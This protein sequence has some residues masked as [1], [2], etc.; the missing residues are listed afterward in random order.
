M[1]DPQPPNPIF[2][3]GSCVKVRRLQG[4]YRVLSS[5]LIGGKIRRYRLDAIPGT[6][7]LLPGTEAFGE[8]MQRVPDP[9]AGPELS[10]APDPPAANSAPQEHSDASPDP[11]APAGERSASAAVCSPGPGITL[12]RDPDEPR[13]PREWTMPAGETN[14]SLPAGDEEV[15][16][17]HDPELVEFREV[18]GQPKSPPVPS[19]VKELRYYPATAMSYR[20]LKNII[21]SSHIRGMEKGPYEELDNDTPVGVA[22]TRETNG[23]AVWVITVRD[24]GEVREAQ[25][26][27]FYPSDRIQDHVMKASCETM[28]IEYGVLLALRKIPIRRNDLEILLL[29]L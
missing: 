5:R 15:D 3:D 12:N 8:D 28:A 27:I 20:D 6:G 25:L 13:D 10:L 24:R 2:A 19:L 14:F 4:E 23:A 18:F 22:V 16:H 7:C 17:T 29:Q 11:A 1:I 9:Q 26:E 21:Y